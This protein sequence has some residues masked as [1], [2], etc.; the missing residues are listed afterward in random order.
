MASAQSVR[1]GSDVILVSFFNVSPHSVRTNTLNGEKDRSSFEIGRRTI[2]SRI[3]DERMEKIDVDGLRFSAEMPDKRR[4]R[5][6]EICIG[7]RQKP[8]H[9]VRDSIELLLGVTDIS[10]NQIEAIQRLFFIAIRNSYRSI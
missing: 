2:Y 6:T 10:T 8:E 3:V 7:V 9:G 5:Q 4:S 1:T